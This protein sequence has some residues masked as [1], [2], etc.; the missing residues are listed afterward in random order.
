MSTEP[1]SALT[2][3]DLILEV[4][5]K[6]GWAS[7]GADGSEAAQIPTNAH[8]L[9]ECTRCVTNAIRMFA[10]DAPASGWR[11]SR[12]VGTF[13][14][15]ADVAELIGRTVSGGSYD[16][17][18]LETTIT[19]SEAVFFSTMEDADLVID[20]VGTFRIKQYVS[21][22]QVIVTGDASTASSDLFSITSTGDYMLPRGFAGPHGGP[23]TFGSNQNQITALRWVDESDIRVARNVSDDVTGYPTMIAVKLAQTVQ[24]GDRRRYVLSVFP[25]ADADTTVE[26]KYHLTL[27]ALVNLTDPIPTPLVHD[28]TIR[29]ACRAV[30]ERDIVRQVDGPDWQY[31]RGNCLPSSHEY[32]SRSGPRRIGYVG[33]P[34]SMGGGNGPVYPL[35]RPTV[36]FEP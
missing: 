11:W 5:I 31:Y 12:P 35:R 24:A 17:T 7:Y 8:D 21:A 14:L 18:N 29:A 1:T 26:F 30:V 9:A 36:R 28:E 13:T 20:S 15:W 32:D 34:D 6:A 27:D 25:R 22:T 16:S 33:N 2:L 19:A 3:S 4:A 10:H 23:I